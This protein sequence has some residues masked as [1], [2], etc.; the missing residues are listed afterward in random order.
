MTSIAPS[1]PSFDPG[2]A[3]IPVDPVVWLVRPLGIAAGMDEPECLAGLTWTRW[4]PGE[5]LRPERIGQA[6]VEFRSVFPDRALLLIAPGIHVFAADA[7]RLEQIACER[8]GPV[9]LTV[10]TNS[11]ETL[12]P[13]AG[14]VSL[15]LRQSGQ[16]DDFTSRELSGLVNLLGDGLLHPLDRWPDH[17]VFLS[18]L[19]VNA[20][21]ENCIPAESAC[22]HLAEIGG[23]LLVSDSVFAVADDRPLS[24]IRA[25]AAHEQRRPAPW[26]SLSARLGHHLAACT[27]VPDHPATSGQTITL[28]ITHSW[29]GG[30]AQ[31]VESF[32]A[33]DQVGRNLQLRSEG[34][35]TGK[36]T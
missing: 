25:L 32:I 30:V 35:Q 28:H 12:N 33:A 8:G 21:A 4:A 29:G 7:R 20:L 18:V 6:L 15:R 14:L 34:P 16:Q 17:L 26:G 11:C 23:G 31:W 5:A 27:P 22:V 9:A 10:L 19:A 24:T 2:V 13:F 3:R 1:T 36:G